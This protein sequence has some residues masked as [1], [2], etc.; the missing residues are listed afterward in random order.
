MQINFLQSLRKGS[1]YKS[2][3]KDKRNW[4]KEQILISIP[5]SG[6]MSWAHL[7]ACPWSHLHHRISR[8]RTLPICFELLRTWAVR[9]H[10]GK[11]AGELVSND[12]HL[13]QSSGRS[14]ALD[15]HN[16]TPPFFTWLLGTC[17]PLTFL[18]PP[19]L[20]PQSPFV[21]LPFFYH[22]MSS[23]Q[24][25]LHI[26]IVWGIFFFLTENQGPLHTN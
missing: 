9:N 25:W 24:S 2:T 7:P 15:C 4:W 22:Y 20:L 26:R 1:C 14:V 19:S 23:S 16:W 3:D 13:A 21:A 5:L 6:G 18:L 11:M 17:N 8:A 10:K 12:W